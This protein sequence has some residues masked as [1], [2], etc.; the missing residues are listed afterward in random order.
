MPK[1][2]L[3]E[4]C[5]QVA[6]DTFSV[7]MAVPTIYVK[8]IDYLETLADEEVGGISEGFA[9]MRLNVSGSAACPI[10]V[11]G[12]WRDLTGQM[13]LERYGMTEIGM[14]LSNPYRGERRPGYVGQ[15]LPDVTVQLV[16]E[17]G[18]IVTGEGTPGEIRIQ[19]PTVFLEYWGNREATDASFSDGWFCTGDIAVI[20]D[21]YY[22]IMGR[23]SVD[24]IKSGGYKL[25]ALEIENKL[26]AHPDIAEV[27]VVGIADRT[28]GEAVAAVVALKG[29]SDMTLDALKSWCD[30]KLS[31]YKVPKQ[32]RVVDALPRNAMGK[33]VKP[34]LKPLF[35]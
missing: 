20:E 3:P 29:D 10:E 1:L 12:E 7:F 4:L 14:A 5:A 8:L 16:D 25:S 17:E 15:A 2:D 31:S 13:L 6:A 23:S 18:V 30:G 32:L 11:F 24:I 27:A 28:W 22:R 19:S 9:N 33:V 34:S 21:G 26:L 35:E